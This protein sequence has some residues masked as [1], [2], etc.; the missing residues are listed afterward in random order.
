MRKEAELSAPVQSNRPPIGRGLRIVVARGFQRPPF[1]GL[2]YS[3]DPR[4][5]VFSEEDNSLNAAATGA[6][7]G[8]ILQIFATGIPSTATVSVQIADQKDLVP[9]YA[10]TAPHRSRRTA[11][12]RSGSRRFCRLRHPDR[13]LR[14][15]RR[16]EGL[17]RRLFANDSVNP[18]GGAIPRPFSDPS[19]NMHPNGKIC[20]AHPLI[21]RE[22]PFY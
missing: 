8:S 7:A 20:F 15:Y 13:H 21:I 9:V 16:A 17:L 14:H 4:S 5:E 2:S 6:K 22:H 19:R 18:W 3:R 10:G 12:Q 11:G 1:G